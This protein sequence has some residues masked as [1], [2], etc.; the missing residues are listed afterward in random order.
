[1][2]CNAVKTWGMMSRQSLSFHL[3]AGRRRKHGQELLLR[4]CTE[5]K[6]MEAMQFD[7]L[8]TAC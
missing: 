4:L 6:M 1:M 7:A 5:D 3:M 2:S 8:L